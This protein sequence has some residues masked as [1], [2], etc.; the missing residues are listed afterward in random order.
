MTSVSSYG[1]S[2]SPDFSMRVHG[3]NCVVNYGS[4]ANFQRAVQ[5]YRFIPEDWKSFDEK[6][7][8]PKKG[9]TRV[10]G[11]FK[12]YIHLSLRKSPSQQAAHTV[13]RIPY[14]RNKYTAEQAIGTGDKTVIDNQVL[15]WLE[16]Q[17]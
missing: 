14:R 5:Q 11:F 4:W 7:F 2:H 1:R 8:H 12:M 13:F 15:E 3:K 10:A 6:V 17:V 9:V 16:A